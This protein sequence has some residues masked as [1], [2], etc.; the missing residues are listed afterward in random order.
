MDD[1]KTASDVSRA[2]DE[3]EVE[4]IETEESKGEIVRAMVIAAVIALLIRTFAFE[5]FNIPSGSM[6]PSLLVGDYLF[7]SKYSY[8]YSQY[9]FPFGIASFDGRIWEK[10]PER[11]DVIVFRQPKHP[12]ID[13]IKR[14][15][16]L[17][18]DTIQVTGGVLHINGEPVQRERVGIHEEE[19]F[20]N[21]F[22]YTEYIE[23]LPNGVKHRIW[24]KSDEEQF[25]NTREFKVPRGYYFMMGD[26]RDS[27]QDSRATAQVG[28]VPAENLV[29]RAEFLF[30]STEGTGDTCVKEDGMFR[31][32]AQFLCNLVTWP[33]V[34]RYSRI[35]DAVH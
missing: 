35:F 22:V 7:V 27:S 32:P 15:I 9:S 1:S 33:Q 3:D 10:Q 20:G 12:E 4:V 21:L 14:L 26:N 6:L 34:I 29:G 13:Y 30:F 18:G 19:E 8:G 24:E 11:G 2:R 5:P 17:P 23:T 25:D 31:L 28:P 16:G